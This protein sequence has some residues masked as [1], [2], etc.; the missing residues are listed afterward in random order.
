MKDK[1][2][3]PVKDHH[4]NPFLDPETLPDFLRPP[5]KERIKG[6]AHVELG[7]WTDLAIG[8][9]KQLH[10]KHKEL[11]AIITA[12]GQEILSLRAEI[13]QLKGAS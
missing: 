8:A 12:Q 11:V 13:D 4:G 7:R 3:K 6:K 2:G 5:P 9:V 10:G 1:Q